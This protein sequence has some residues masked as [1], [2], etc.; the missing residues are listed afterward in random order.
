LA[1][2]LDEIDPYVE[3]K[4]ALLSRILERAGLTDEERASIERANRAT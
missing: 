1:S 3:A 4:S 2:R